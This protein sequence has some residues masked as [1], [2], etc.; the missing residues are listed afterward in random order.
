MLMKCVKVMQENDFPLISV[1]MGVYYRNGDT[2]ILRHS[3]ESI[4]NQT[5]SDFEFLICDDGSSQQ[6]VEMLNDISSTDNRVKLLRKGNL[7][8]LPQKL[9]YCLKNAKGKYIARMDDDDWSYPMRFETQVSALEC[10]DNIAFVGSNVELWRNGVCVGERILPENPEKEDFLFVQPF[11]H[12][13][14]IF[15]REALNSVGGYSEDKHVVLCEDYDILLRLYAM[16]YKGKNL[17]EKLLRYT[18][19]SSQ[20]KKRRMKYRINE[21]VTRFRRFKE[22]KMLP[23]A[24]PYVFKPVVVGLIPEKVLDRLKR[25]KYGSY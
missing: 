10:C 23:K 8:S 6:A 11:I 9:N 20:T 7:I 17:S 3:V 16:S 25:R 19:P 12:P 1:I 15:R 2:G 24:L 21:S 14:L 4:L 5:I 18:L 13:A 22:L